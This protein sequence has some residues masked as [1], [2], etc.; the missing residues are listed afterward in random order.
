MSYIEIKNVSKYYG[1][2][3][4]LNNIN[5]QI[6]EGRIIGLL[7]KNGAGKST[8]MR[9]ILGFLKYDGEIKVLSKY[10]NERNRSINNEIAFIPD[11][12]SLDDR[13]TVQQTM[14][15]V[16]A[17][18]DSWNQEKADKLLKRSELPL[19]RKVGQLSKG[20]KTKLYLL[21][22]LSLD[23]KILLLDEPTLGLDIVFRKE[24]FNTILG[25][26]YTQDKTIIISTHQVE[27]VEQI[28][29]DI[30]FINDGNIILY[31]D[32]EELKASYNVVTV[33]TDRRLELELH[34]PLFFTETLGH[35]SGIIKSDVKIPNAT[36]SRPT[37]S[38]LFVA[39]VGGSNEKV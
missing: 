19:T 21:I 27:E 26:F 6:P 8:L 38:D 37:L 10:I 39:K 22:T 16:A 15:Y 32:V 4:A 29:Q 2:N 9:C 14:N 7:G 11:V 30:I 5:L 3:K 23:V 24:F 20:M 35:V 36:Y 34:N 28:L 12:S 13:L 18:N 25:E 33:T 17:L 1:K 31:E